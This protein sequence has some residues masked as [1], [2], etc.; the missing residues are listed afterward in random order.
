VEAEQEDKQRRHQR[1]AA[2][3]RHAHQRSDQETRKRVEWVVA[4]KGQDAV[5]QIA[6]PE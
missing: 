6:I 2:D 3:T 1:T 5:R 4:G